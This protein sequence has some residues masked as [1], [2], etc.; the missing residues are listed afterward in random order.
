MAI[1]DPFKAPITI[2]DLLLSKMPEPLPAQNLE[3]LQKVAARD[4]TSYSE[5]EVRSYVIDPIVEALGYEKGTVFGAS[6]EHRVTFL[7]KHIFPDYQLTLWNENFWLIEAKKPSPNK[8]AFDS[9]DL[10][11]A[12]EYSVHP[13]VNA[14]LVV[15]CDGVKLEIFDREADVEA[16]VLRVEIRSIATEF[17]K[18]RAI[19]EP[20]QVWFFQKRR[21]VRLIDKVFD[22][23]FNMNRIEEFG[24]LIEDRLRSKQKIVLENFR[25]TSKSDEG[26]DVR[27]IADTSACDLVEMYFF[28]DHPIPV[29]NAIDRRLAALSMPNSFHVMYRIFPDQPRDVNDAYMGRA[30]SYLM[31]LGEQAPKA[32][33]MP[34]WLTKDVADKQ[35]IEGVT[36]HLFKQ[37]LT[38]FEDH[39]DYRTILLAANTFLRIA[40]IF[41][42]TTD[43]VRT[44]GMQMHA[45]ARYELP[46]MSWGQFLASPEGQLIAHMEATAMMATKQFVQRNVISNSGFKAESARHELRRLWQLERELL[47]SIGNY[48]KLRAERSLGEIVMVEWSSVVY[49]NL[50]HLSLCN[51]KFFPKWTAFVLG[52][53]LPLVAKLAAMGSWSARDLL[54]I[55]R[56]ANFDPLEDTEIAQRFFFGDVDTLVA[57]RGFY[58][59]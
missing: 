52:E 17:N 36:K 12:I 49:D 43:A 47:Q 59:G 37:C 6:L 8:L 15:L 13:A 44:K 27:F 48:T 39:E 31:R 2:E 7:G 24:K 42:I 29:V 46:E 32:Q 10:R 33:W 18:V 35:D 1:K 56:D 50:G 9:D 3:K 41:A 57:L 21:V 19:L 34:D 4:V 45:L 28:H 26:A 5:M 11:Q 58:R 38:Y 14:S 23:E 22:N 20:M 51:L 30:L 54:G 53:Y 25:K 55:A 40:K 16:P